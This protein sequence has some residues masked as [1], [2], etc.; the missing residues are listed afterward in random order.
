[1]KNAKPVAGNI[2]LVGMMGSG[3]DSVAK[4]LAARNGM[5]IIDTDAEIERAAGMR[6]KEIFS[7]EGETGFRK[8]E[9]EVIASLGLDGAK[10]AII[11]CGGGAVISGK[12]RELLGRNA[13][14]VWLWA[15]IST[16][17]ARVPKDGSRP[18]LGGV[19]PEKKLVELLAERKGAYSEASGLVLATDGKTPG[20]I[21]E[22]IAYE[23]R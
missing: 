19:E 3:K 7:K 18:L 2:A 15:D 20:E 4:A 21:A 5:P 1:M 10:P 17:M 11:N 12:N 13:T 22:R 14:V 8:R 16:I 9:C 23:I 6:I